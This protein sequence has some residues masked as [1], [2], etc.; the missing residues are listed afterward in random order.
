[1]AACATITGKI[2]SPVN[3]GFVYVLLNPAFPKQVKIG[4]TFRHPERRA[5][6]L[7]RQTGVPEDYIVM[8]YEMVSDAPHVEDLLHT[9]FSEYRTKRNKEFFR[10][11]PRDVIKALQEIAIRFPVPPTTPSLEADLF[12]HFRQNFGA[13]LDSAV[14]GIRLVQLPGFCFLN[15]TRQ[16]NAGH[17]PVTKQDEIPLSGIRAQD[18]PTLDVLRANEALLRSLDAYDWIMISDLFPEET[19]KQIAQEWEKPGGK[20]DMRKQHG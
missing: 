3:I 11:P 12:P 15:V 18:T 13:Y 14:I 6:D 4:R 10:V 20:L 2:R 7:S 5:T 8:Y 16:P 19:A 9:K 17:T 1:M